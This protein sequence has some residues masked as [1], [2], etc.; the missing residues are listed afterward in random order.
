MLLAVAVGAT[1]AIG[2]E[3]QKRIDNAS[4]VLR[5]MT[6]IPSDVWQRANCVI[7]IPSV[8]KAAFMIGGEYGKGVASCRTSNGWT[9]PAF[10]ELEKGSWGFQIGGETVDLVL[11]VMNQAGIEHLLQDKVALGASGSLAAGPVG[12]SATALTD[13]Q[14][15]A[16]MLAYSRAQGLFAGVDLTGGVLMPDKDA[17]TDAYGPKVTS[18]DILLKHTVPA[19]PAAR[20]FE[21]AL[22]RV[23]RT[24]GTPAGGI[25]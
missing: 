7:V 8:K 2:R 21:T 24:Q 25:K 11:T 18:R 20:P 15:H 14:L 22:L 4:T 6:N 13:A 23:D 9:A 12:R 16:E 10:V 3:E 19:P 5:D 17:N 1:A